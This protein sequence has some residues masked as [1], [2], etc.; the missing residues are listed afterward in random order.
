MPYAHNTIGIYKIVNS[1]SGKIYVGQSQYCEKR[2]SEHFRL[3]RKNK[4]P[5]KILQKSFD[6]HGEASFVSEIEVICED[7]SELDQLEEAFISGKIAL[8]QWDLC[9]IAKH[10]RAPMRGKRHT[11]ETKEKIKQTKQANPVFASAEALSKG[12]K[13]RRLADTEHR[14]KVMQILQMRNDGH[15]FKT[16]AQKL[17]YADPTTPWAIYRNYRN[18]ED[19]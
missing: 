3:L 9:N 17:G 15:T 16:I 2:I 8:E 13:R 10:A 1:D 5:N 7:V 6:K 18:V 14:A 4:H 19:L 12:Q 11:E